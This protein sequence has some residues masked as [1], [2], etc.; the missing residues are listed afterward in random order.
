[1]ALSC[2]WRLLL[3]VTAWAITP[4]SL[5]DSAV[6]VAV[7]EN[8]LLLH[9][10]V[11][12]RRT[13][14]CGIC[15]LHVVSG[16][17]RGRRVDVAA[18]IVRQAAGVA[19]RRGGLQTVA[20]DGLRRQRAAVPSHHTHRGVGLRRRQAPL[21]APALPVRLCAADSAIVPVALENAAPSRLLSMRFTAT[22]E[23][24]VLLATPN[25]VLAHRVSARTPIMLYVV[26]PAGPMPLLEPLITYVALSA[27]W[28]VRARHRAGDFAV[29]ADGMVAIRGQGREAF[30]AQLVD[31]SCADPQAA[32][33]GR[34]TGAAV[35][36]LQQEVVKER[37]LAGA[38]SPHPKMSCRRP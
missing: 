25:L 38:A 5:T 20:S 13:Q 19:T 30:G 34:Q 9:A 35:A 32:V 7:S 23:L 36:Q 27:T 37:R 10:G 26:P 12:H 18:Q 22:A 16:H 28:P 24:T 29:A 3:L 14:H 33:A 11:P 1:M 4:F 21:I 31:A 6:G 2:T 8:R 15:G 17:R